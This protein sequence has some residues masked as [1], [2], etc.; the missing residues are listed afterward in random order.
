MDGKSCIEKEVI[1]LYHSQKL[2]LAR[3]S[4]ALF[5]RD[6][7]SFDHRFLFTVLIL[8]EILQS[9]NLIAP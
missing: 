1:S 2:N 9:Y 6:A 8:A 4:R 5:P 7:Q 3:K